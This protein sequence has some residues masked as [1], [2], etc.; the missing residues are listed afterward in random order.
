MK[1]SIFIASS[2]E[3]LDVAYAIQ[4]ELEYESE[5]TVWNQGVFDL[6]KYALDDL[7]KVLNSVDIAIFVFSPDDEAV[8]RDDKCSIIRDNVIFELG[9]FLGKLDREKV[10]II[11]PRSADNL[12]IPSDLIG[13]TPGKYDSNRSDANLRAAVGPFCN[14]IRQNFKT[15]QYITKKQIYHDDFKSPGKWKLNHWK[16]NISR[17]E[18]QKL[19]LEGII[20][21]MKRQE[22]GCHIDL[23]NTVQIGNKYEIEVRAMSIPGTDAKMAIWVHD[24]IDKKLPLGSK[25]FTDFI[26][27]S[28]EGDVIKAIYRADYNTNMRLHLQYKPGHGRIEVEEINIYEIV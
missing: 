3:G 7:F 25:T 14:Q 4:S 22:D 16:N 8:I 19:V 20:D 11:Q 1:P 10:F 27:P 2:R 23:V 12:R 17:I 15:I 13:I 26:T 9:L 5:P 18:N 28:K 24:K 21:R 6:S